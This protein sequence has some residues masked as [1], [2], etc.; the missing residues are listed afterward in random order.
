MSLKKILTV[1][2]F[3]FLTNVSATEIYCDF[4][5]EET[6]VQTEAKTE[7]TLREPANFN[8]LKHL[9]FGVFKNFLNASNLTKNLL[10]LGIPILI[11]TKTYNENIFY[12]IKS[13]KASQKRLQSW[14]NKTQKNLG[15]KALTTH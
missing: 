2:I 5:E 6:E 8:T 14:T 7:H 1:F 10:N 15:L 13:Q 12:F 11:D 9:Q 3:L 4:A